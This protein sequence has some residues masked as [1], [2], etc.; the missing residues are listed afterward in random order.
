MEFLAF[1][2]VL[3]VGERAGGKRQSD[4]DGV[5]ELIRLQALQPP[6]DDGRGDR[7]K[8]GA[9]LEPSGLERARR[10]KTQADEQLPAQHQRTQQVRAGAAMT[11]RSNQRGRDQHRTAM[12]DAGYMGVVLFHGVNQATQEKGRFRS[13]Q[14]LHDRPQAD[15]GAA[16]VQRL[17][18]AVQSP[19]KIVSRNRYRQG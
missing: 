19:T 17:Q 7:A 18:C 9:G 8:H 3:K 12:H 5:P 15:A 10:V 2:A 13:G 16:A 6:R 11:H 14:A 1:G 4:P